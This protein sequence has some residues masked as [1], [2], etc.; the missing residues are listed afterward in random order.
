MSVNMVETGGKSFE[1]PAYVSADRAAATSMTTSASAPDGTT[2]VNKHESIE[3]I[4]ACWV[5]M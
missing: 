4:S 1:N 5:C 3:C 2:K